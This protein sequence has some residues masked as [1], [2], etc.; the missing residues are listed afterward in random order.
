M[1]A[2]IGK[3]WKKQ[4]L[5]H[6]LFLLYPEGPYRPCGIRAPT[7]CRGPGARGS[8][9]ACLELYC[10]NCKS[11]STEG[12]GRE[13]NMHV[14]MSALTQGSR[15]AVQYVLGTE[16]C[17]RARVFLILHPSICELLSQDVP[18]AEFN[19][20][21]IRDLPSTWAFPKFCPVLFTP[22]SALLFY[23]LSPLNS[24]LL[25]QQE[26]RLSSSERCPVAP[27]NP[28]LS[29]EKRDDIQ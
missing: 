11:R 23:L 17:T 6:L 22:F 15:G 10:L 21:P 1:Q 26:K 7:S 3:E 18:A 24:L 8:P 20:L 14:M 29:S 16:A 12:I 5:A 4:K 19:Y 13:S 25:H 28:S 9:K 27:C 2:T